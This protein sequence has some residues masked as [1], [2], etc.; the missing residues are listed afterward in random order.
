MKT[1]ETIAA[2]STA[3]GNAA[4]GVIR[5]SGNH[6]QSIITKHIGGNL[7]PRLAT[8]TLIKDN[9]GKVIDSV[10]AIFYETPKSYTGEDMLEIQTHGNPVILN[11]IIECLCGEHAR[12]A[13]PGEFTERAFLN[14]KI[15]LIQAEAVMDIINS[16]NSNASKSAIKSLQGRFSEK[17]NN[18]KSMILNLRATIEASINFPE[19]EVP[20]IQLDKNNQSI[21]VIISELETIIK[22]AVSGVAINCKT[23]FAIVGK[24]NVGKSSLSNLLLGEQG[25]IV[26]SRPGT[27]RDTIQH[28]ISFKKSIV[29]F[30]DTAGL[31]SPANKIESEGINLTKKTIL[32]SSIVLYMVDD[33]CGF[34]KADAQ[35]IT[36]NNIDNYWLINNK[37]DKTNKKPSFFE[38]NNIKNFSVSVLEN[39]GIDL[40]IN[41]IINLNLISDENIG[42]ARQR[43]LDLLKKALDH[44]YMVKKYNDNQGLDIVAEELRC[45]HNII[46]E[47][48][49][50]QVN[51][52]LLDKVF[53]DFC[54]GK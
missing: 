7:L 17:I 26:S 32:K 44:L 33:T 40:L 23:S 19:D 27:T 54:I 49:G 21:N 48:L 11:S 16:T 41:E 46:D 25:S 47:I 1:T 20:D 45:A 50:G 14:N 37:I 18:I 42:T 51:K 4:I 35:I 9:E 6:V 3:Y 13:N 5:I 53:S 36:D 22:S 8:N 43:H 15:D 29:T 34:D 52:E 2:I 28:E 12:L 39:L 31:R 38:Q 10:I 30:Y 24:P